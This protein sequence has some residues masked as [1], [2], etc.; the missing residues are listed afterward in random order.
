MQCTHTGKTRQERE[1]GTKSACTSWHLQ[2]PP[3]QP[4]TREYPAAPSAFQKT[5][6]RKTGALGKTVSP[7]GRVRDRQFTFAAAVQ[8]LSKTFATLPHGDC[9]SQW[10]RHD[11]VSR[12]MR[13]SEQRQLTS[14]T[15]GM[16]AR[17]IISGSQS[18]HFTLFALLSFFV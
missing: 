6:H 16:T 4:G 15:A 14:G 2:A 13:S 5:V 9:A 18:H 17:S 3:T 11:I 7:Q 10:T 12:R 1:Q 8:M